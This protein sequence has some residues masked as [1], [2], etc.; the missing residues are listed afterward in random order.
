MQLG[1]SLWHLSLH[2]AAFK[3][4]VE[5]DVDC[6]QRSETACSVRAKTALYTFTIATPCEL[7]RTQIYT[8]THID[9][10]E[11]EEL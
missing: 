3:C 10:E 1:R 8:H 2:C 6:Y 9:S 7:Q 11:A 4:Q 5:T